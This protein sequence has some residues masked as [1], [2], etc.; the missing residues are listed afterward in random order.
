MKTKMRVWA[1][2]FLVAGATVWMAGAQSISDNFSTAHN[3]LT[4]GVVGTIWDGIYYGY[5]DIAG[6]DPSQGT[7]YGKT[8]V[9][10]AGISTPGIL[11]IGSVDG[12]WSYNGD[13]GFFLWK[14]VSG[15]FTADI[16]VVNLPIIGYNCSGLMARIPN[17]ADAGAGEDYEAFFRFDEYGIYNY[18]RKVDDNVETDNGLTTPNTNYYIRLER[19]V[20]LI[21]DVYNMYERAVPTDP[22]TLVW[23]DYRDDTVGL[24]MQVGLMMGT[25]SDNAAT[26]QLGGFALAGTNVVAGGGPAAASNLAVT[27]LG[28]GIV[29]V[30]WSPGAGSSGSLVAVRGGHDP[31]TQLT[32]TNALIT[33]QPISGQTYT[34]N[35]AFGA[36]DDLSGSDSNHVHVVYAGSGTNVTITGLSGGVNYEV[37]VWSYS[38]SGAST[39]YT[40]TN[41]PQQAFVGPAALLSITLS[42]PTN[43]VAEADTIQATVLANF[44][45]GSPLDVTAQASFSSTNTSVA[46]V[47]AG[48]L[49]TGTGAGTTTIKASYM[50]FTNSSPVTVIKLPVTDDFST[51]RDYLTQG[52]AGTFWNGILRG[53]SDT[54]SGGSKLFP[55][56]DTTVCDSSITTPGRLTVVSYGTDWTATYDDGFLLYRMVAGDF[57]IQI[58]VPY[59]DPSAYNWPGLMARA[60][61]GFASAENYVALAQFGFGLGNYGRSVLNG[62]ESDGPFSGTTEAHPFIMLERQTNRFNF[63]VKDHALD[64]W[65]LLGFYDRPDLDGV[66]MQ[67]GIEQ[68]TFN[69]ISP[70]S[71]F[72][73]LVFSTPT[74][75]PPGKPAAATG[76][77]LARAGLGAVTA[78]WT[79]GAGSDGSVVVMRA[80]PI[81]RQ[82]IDGTSYMVGQDL[83]PDPG[84]SNTVVYVGGGS[85][86]TVSDLPPVPYSF[87]VY[88][89]AGGN[90]YNWATPAATI[91][92][93]AAPQFTKNP[94]SISRY[95]GRTA[96]FNA[97]VI[98]TQP[99]TFQW[100][101]NDTNRLVDGP[102]I[103]GATTTNLTITSLVASDA[104]SYTLVATNEAGAQTS[105]PPATL[106][107]LMPT[108]AWEMAVASYGP[109]AYY[110]FNEASGT[111]IAS[112]AWGGNDATCDPLTSFL[113][114]AGPRP[115]D[116][117]SIFETSNTGIG[118]DGTA[119]TVPATTPPLNLNTNTVTILCWIKPTVAPNNDRAG[120]FTYTGLGRAG[121]RYDT[122]GNNLG[123]L[124]NGAVYNSTMGIP[125]SVWS[126][127]GLV[128]SPTQLTLYL[129]NTGSGLQSQSF[130]GSF[131]P[132]AFNTAGLI[133]NDSNVG[134]RYYN[135]VLDELAIFKSALP[136]AAITNL[137][138]GV[139]GPPLITATASGN[140]LVLTWPS[141]YSGYTLKTSPRVE[142]P[143]LTWS[144]VPDAPVATNWYYMVTLPMTNSTAYYLLHK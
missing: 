144:T 116:G 120:L 103:F 26:N 21:Q 4:Q 56:G 19:V 126:F 54:P 100:V 98:G 5:G 60:P 125:A 52:I 76:L 37:A 135:G 68:A 57:Q 31:G 139:A 44:D 69:T 81:T 124:W 130:S 117:F 13:D 63:Y 102:R 50:G 25:F 15:S 138:Q 84:S 41:A 80:G 51:P 38:G 58:Q 129:G 66:A 122:G 119:T 22:W 53:P 36:G 33:R 110:R 35:T 134:G 137:Y 104:G 7:P 27:N 97:G 46:T 11:T 90:I 23:T 93:L 14:L 92:P 106:T 99:M 40:L 114:L 89:Y 133:D 82:P 101:Q 115:V 72:D 143:Y 18:P 112:D 136:P 95:A 127:A 64:S 123:S 75:N 28:S 85:S 43:T 74:L 61:F 34:G 71:Q 91:T 111:T 42:L 73:N 8:L 30:T 3:Y 109:Y 70:V 49:I 83:D 107:V 86:V 77:T 55:A 48:G 131:A 16:H 20:G 59:F 6:L 2:G 45:T 10:D 17:L 65:T 113:G 12:D 105:A 118:F 94:A 132:E 79:P 29:Q 140:T 108:T 47:A 32:V 78:T 87:A 128:V 142:A 67:V 141:F 24:P 88:S 9:A 121:L 62:V 1:V 39:L 96:Q